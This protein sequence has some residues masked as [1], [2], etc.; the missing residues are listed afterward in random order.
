MNMFWFAFFFALKPFHANARLNQERADAS[1]TKLVQNTQSSQ[2]ELNTPL[3]SFGGH[4]NL[5]QALNQTQTLNRTDL[6]EFNLPPGASITMDLSEEYS[7][8][9]ATS[10][11][12]D[13]ISAYGLLLF[14]K[15]GNL[16][17]S[18]G[19]VVSRNISREEDAV[20]VTSNTHFTT[21]APTPFPYSKVEE[22]A[23]VSLKTLAKITF[24]RS[25]EFLTL[26][27]PTT[28]MIFSRTVL[29]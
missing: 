20:R 4:W 22:Y 23:E 27:S 10:N 29:W 24:N 21:G 5:T 6:V 17:Y 25:T 28:K 14:V 11:A 15:N 13:A 19:D 16:L 1:I 2:R 3:D 8:L 26:T 9:N 12:T 18:A 7:S